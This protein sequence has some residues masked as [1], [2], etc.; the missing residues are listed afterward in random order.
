MQDVGGGLGHLLATEA[1]L[2]RALAAAQ[3]EADGMLI[4]ARTAADQDEAGLQQTIER[5]ILALTD[6]IAAEREAE[7]SRIT[8]TAEERVR[9]YRDLPSATLEE[10]ALELA[11][12]VLPP[13][14][15]EPPP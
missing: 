8:A 13:P 12:R 5:E 6:R 4:A 7:L 1:R 3:A 2:A 11:D 14:M 10:L 9:G 15:P